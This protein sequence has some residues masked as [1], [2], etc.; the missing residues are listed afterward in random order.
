MERKSFR[1][2]VVDDELIV[3]DS[4][5]EWLM[6]EGFDADMAGSG[7]EALSRLG[8]SPFQLMLLDIKMPGMDGVEVLKKA[9]EIAP[10]VNVV[11]MT[12]YATVETAIEAMK[13][14]A[15]EYLIKPFEIDVLMPMVEKRFAEFMA[16][17]D[18]KIRVGAIVLAGGTAFYNP[19]RR[20]KHA[21]VWRLS[22]Y[23]HQPGIRTPDQQCR[24]LCGEPHPVRRR[25]AHI[26]DCVDSVR[27]LTGSASRRG[28]LLQHLLHDFHQGSPAGP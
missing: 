8:E 24:P 22:Q 14:G 7:Q 1:I 4:I 11:M 20:Q 18:E 6:E 3:R 16:A 25:K 15:L 13:T 23:A 21:G 2:L 10:E 12:A 9:R 28:F 5:R 27:G 26:P 19:S 17:R